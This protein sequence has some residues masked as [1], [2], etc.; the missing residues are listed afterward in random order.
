MPTNLTVNGQTFAYPVPRD[1]NWGPAATG[2]ASAVTALIAHLRSPGTPLASTGQIRFSNADSIAWRNFTNTLNMELFVDSNDDLIFNDGTTDINLTL[3]AAGNVQNNTGSTDNA[4]ARYDGTGGTVIQD[5]GVI[6]DDSDNVL[7]PGSITFSADAVDLAKALVPIG[8]VVP[9]YDFN[10]DLVPDSTYW[11]PCD[12]GTYTIGGSSRVTPDLSGRY[13]VGFGTDGGGDNH[14]AA[15]ATT[16]VGN[17]GHT[18]DL[19]HTHTLAHTHPVDPPSTSTSSNGAHTHDEGS[20]YAQIGLPSTP[21]TRLD[22]FEV[23]GLSAWNSTR[24]CAVTNDDSGAGGAFTVGI[25]VDGTTASNGAHTHTVDIASF[26]SGAASTSDTGTALSSTQ[27]IQ[28]RS[29][30]FRFYMRAK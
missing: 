6:I 3:A 10:G 11:K 25:K 20:L 7:V 8:T 27:S 4:I 26:T 16:P 21:T 14:S 1:E 9:H 15:W 17:A 28:P 19:S 13:I 22:F 24:R 5:S 18:V 12:G 30:R 2:W 29:I 23:T